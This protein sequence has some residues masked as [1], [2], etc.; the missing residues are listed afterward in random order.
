M[1][2]TYDDPGLTPE[3]ARAAAAWLEETKYPGYAAADL[4]IQAD[5]LE[6]AA[7]TLGQIN[8]EA[9]YGNGYRTW[10]ELQPWQ[11]DKFEDGAVAVI[12]HNTGPARVEAVNPNLPT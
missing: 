1:S 4:R 5:R 7:K 2:T 8:Y 10:G 11:R 6:D 9:Q 3:A 12:A